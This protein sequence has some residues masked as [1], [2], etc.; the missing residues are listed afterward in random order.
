MTNNFYFKMFLTNKI[1]TLLNFKLFIKL[2]NFWFL[3]STHK[4]KKK[5]KR[6]KTIHLLSPSIIVANILCIASPEGAREVNVKIPTFPRHF[7]FVGRWE[8]E[9][10]YHSIWERQCVCVWWKAK[11]KNKFEW[12]AW[13]LFFVLFCDTWWPSLFFW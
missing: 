3:L 6:V 1:P 11:K 8:M 2:R 7:P 4:R 10:I 9:N 5:K 13:L 12:D